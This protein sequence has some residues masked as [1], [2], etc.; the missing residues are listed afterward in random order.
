M[1]LTWQIGLPDCPC[2]VSTCRPW[3]L[4]RRRDL[5]GA[6]ALE[7]QGFPASFVQHRDRRIPNPVLLTLAG[8]AMSGYVLMAVFLGIFSTAEWQTD[9]SDSISRS[10]GNLE[11]VANSLEQGDGDG[12]DDIDGEAPDD[13]D[14]DDFGAGSDSSQLSVFDDFDGVPLRG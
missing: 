10:E 7:L 14:L 11:E 3:I 8:N 12:S 9:D 1:R 13:L 2:L 4:H 6:E 5:T